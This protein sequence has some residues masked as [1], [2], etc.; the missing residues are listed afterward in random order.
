[1]NY[2]LAK[3]ISSD[4]LQ[5][6]ISTSYEKHFLKFVALARPCTIFEST[7]E[8]VK[9]YRSWIIQTKVFNMKES[10]LKKELLQVTMVL[11]DIIVY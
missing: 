6:S 11:I 10:V 1:V 3:K 9:G 4:V 5:G 8:Y 7:Q 2:L